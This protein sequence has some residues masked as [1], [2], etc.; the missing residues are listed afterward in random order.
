VLAGV[1]DDIV[2][3][4]IDGGT[5]LPHCLAHTTSLIRIVKP[6]FNFSEG[7]CSLDRYRRVRYCLRPGDLRLA[8]PAGRDGADPQRCLMLKRRVVF[9]G[10]AVLSGRRRTEGTM[11]QACGEMRKGKDPNFGFAGLRQE[12]NFCSGSDTPSRYR[13]TVT[14]L[15][16]ISASL[17]LLFIRIASS[18]VNL[19]GSTTYLPNFSSTILRCLGLTFV[20]EPWRIEG[21]M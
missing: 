5:T 10:A 3:A 1:L 11:K 6:I 2:V 19:F 16:T 4:T 15:P 14:N 7:Y 20:Y 12:Y 17:F 21:S 18:V 9:E 13:L 8:E